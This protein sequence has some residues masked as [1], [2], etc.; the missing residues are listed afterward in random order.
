MA[1]YRLLFILASVFIWG[2]LLYALSKVR[3]TLVQDFVDNLTVVK[4]EKEKKLPPPP[5]PP[6]P[7]EKLPPPPPLVERKTTVVVDIPP[8]PRDEIRQV[9]ERAPPP[10]APALTDYQPPAPPP[11]PPAPPPPPPPPPPPAPPPP[12]PPPSCTEADSAA[13]RLRPFNTERAYPQRAIDRGT[14]GSVTATLQISPAGDVV[15]V[16][17]TAANPPGVFDQ[18]VDREARRMKYAP[19]RR[20]CQDV[21]DSVTLQASFTLGE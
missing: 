1:K 2:G 17:I 14:E 4:A 11:P 12:P 18:A 19:A 20:N 10:P 21:A 13:R 5:P 9:V 16:L 6:P 7:P 3:P 15:G 8:P